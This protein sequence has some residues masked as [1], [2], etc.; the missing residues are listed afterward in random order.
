MDYIF[1]E[2]VHPHT[3][4]FLKNIYLMLSLPDHRYPHPF[5]Q[6]IENMQYLP[7]QLERRAERMFL[8]IADTSLKF[9]DRPDEL[10]AV[11]KLLSAEAEIA[12]DL[13]VCKPTLEFL[14]I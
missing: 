4:I 7:H 6:E 10:D 3:H 11:V 1:Y 2:R 13:E 14:F 5:R 12:V 9:V 8:P